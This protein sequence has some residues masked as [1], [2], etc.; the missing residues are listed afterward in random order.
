MDMDPS[1][2]AAQLVDAL[3]HVIAHTSV[4]VNVPV[5]ALVNVPAIAL[6]NVDLVD[7]V[8]MLKLIVAK[9]LPGTFTLLPPAPLPSL[10]L[11]SPTKSAP[12]PPP[13]FLTPST[14]SPL[15]LLI[16]L[17]IEVWRMCNRC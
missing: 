11:Q 8:V 17:K 1:V 3:T 9:L 15:S 12:L 4:P 16:N 5:N 7:L 14:L 13:P 6:V 10:Q 2:D